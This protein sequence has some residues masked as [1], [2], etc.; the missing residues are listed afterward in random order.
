MA[1]ARRRQDGFGRMPKP[2]CPLAARLR[3][4]RLAALAVSE[5]RIP[6]AL[7][8]PGALPLERKLDPRLERRIGQHFVAQRRQV[9]RLGRAHSELPEPR[10]YVPGLDIGR[11]SR[12]GLS[13]RGRSALLTHE[14]GTERLLG[15]VL[16]VRPAAQPE[17]FN[18]RPAAPRDR[19]HVV[20][21]ESATRAA[22]SSGFAHEAAGAPIALPHCALHRR[23]NVTPGCRAPRRV[24]R[25]L[26][27]SELPPLQPLD[28]QPK[29]HLSHRSQ[30][31]IRYLVSQERPRVL[32]ILVCAPAHR[33][34]Q[35]HPIMRDGLDARWR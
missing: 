2:S 15:R 32:Q 19:L 13:S 31:S 14:R 30:I 4:S 33:Q 3:R 24:R 9:S 25:P 22:P 29:R 17:V 34:M 7:D 1:E 26:R 21:L 16:V 10:R 5:P 28:Q 12:C 8:W 27:R 6:A 11:S 20:E 23:R 35:R 18:S